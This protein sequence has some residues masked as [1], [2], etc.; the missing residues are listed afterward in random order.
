MAFQVNYFS[1][2]IFLT[3][4]VWNLQFLNN[5]QKFILMIKKSAIVQESKMEN[6]HLRLWPNSFSKHIYICL[7][8]DIYM[9]FKT[10]MGW[11]ACMFVCIRVCAKSCK[12]QWHCFCLCLYLCLHLPLAATRQVFILWNNNKSAVVYMKSHPLLNTCQNSL[13]NPTEAQLTPTIIAQPAARNRK[14]CTAYLL[15]TYTL[16]FVVAVSFIPFR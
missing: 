2:A 12:Y 9:Y 7:Y 5:E 16:A 14:L 4:N 11:N 10:L 6:F 8:A 15:Q 3:E 13:C 1:F